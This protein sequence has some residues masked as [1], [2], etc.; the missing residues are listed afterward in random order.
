MSSVRWFARFG[1]S[2]TMFLLACGLATAWFG[3]GLQLPA[4]TARDGTL[5]TLNRYVKEPVPEVVIVGSSL[6]FRLNENYF[7]TKLRNLALAGGSPVTGLEL[8]INQPRLPKIVLVEANV[9]SRATDAA[10]VEKYSSKGNADPLFFRPI[11]V[12]VAAYESWHHAPLG[13]TQVTLALSQLLKQPASNFD[14]SIYVD[15]AV[16][17]SNAEDVEA[18]VR[19]NVARIEDLIAVLERR[20]RGYY[21]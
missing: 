19:M 5:I 14:N 2:A 6:S 4:A 16:Q 17:Q 7:A 20:G 18:A 11:R 8:V 10:L 1:L 13:H 3:N 15:R 21:F 12:A 9:L